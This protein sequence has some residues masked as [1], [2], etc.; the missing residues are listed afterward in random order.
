MLTAATASAPL[1]AIWAAIEAPPLRL[2]IAGSTLQAGFP[3]PRRPVS[4]SRMAVLAAATSA[5]L[6]PRTTIWLLNAPSL[7]FG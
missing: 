1:A 2:P 5:G 6:R 7:K 3:S 4:D